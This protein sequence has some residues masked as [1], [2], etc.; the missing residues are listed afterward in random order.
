MGKHKIIYSTAKD[1]K[2]A[3]KIAKILLEEKLVACVNIFKINSIYKWKGKVMKNSEY[4][5]IIKTKDELISKAM[6]RIKE[7]HSYEVPCIICFDIE[8][9]YEKFLE[10]IDKELSQR[11]NYK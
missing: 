1:K 11:G 5:M 4:A 6:K 10:W 9:G 8:K 3:E 7:L 2:E